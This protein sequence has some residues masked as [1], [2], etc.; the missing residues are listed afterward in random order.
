MW[1]SF[2]VRT[3]AQWR[4]GGRGVDFATVVL[5]WSGCGFH[6][7]VP[8]VVGVWFSR[9]TRAKDFDAFSPIFG[10]KHRCDLSDCSTIV[11]FDDNAHF[12]KGNGSNRCHAKVGQKSSS[13]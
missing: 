8:T 13:G 10:L 2:V 5:R 9:H 12:Q 4:S 11:F 1:S 6:G 7:C 3:P